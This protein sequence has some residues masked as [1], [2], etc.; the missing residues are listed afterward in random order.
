M[1]STG[2]KRHETT[3]ARPGAPTDAHAAPC[4][5]RQILLGSE[6]GRGLLSTVRLTV[7]AA[8]GGVASD[9]GA[10]TFEWLTAVHA[11]QPE[12]HAKSV[13]FSRAIVLFHAAVFVTAIATGQWVFVF[14][15][16]VHS[17]FGGW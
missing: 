14:I 11:D 6:R 12:E 16:N 5:R 9:P 10:E 2:Q 15:I 7:K 17:F 13:W 1:S 8:L 4:E 3:I